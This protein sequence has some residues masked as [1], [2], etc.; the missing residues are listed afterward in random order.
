L[1][2]RVT[3]LPY[4]WGAGFNLA[5]LGFWVWGLRLKCGV[6]DVGFAE[7]GFGGSM[8]LLE[9]RVR[10]HRFG[11]EREAR[12]RREREAERER[13]PG[14]NSGVRRGWVIDRGGGQVTLA[15]GRE[16]VP[17]HPVVGEKSR[18]Q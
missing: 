3:D 7:Q 8:M 11:G 16:R 2:F 10:H 1:A 4:V 12:E 13:R 6:E 9:P 17:C 18:G 15:D 14:T 5:C